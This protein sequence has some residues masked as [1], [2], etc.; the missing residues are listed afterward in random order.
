MEK[1]KK[2]RNEPGQKSKELRRQTRPM[3]VVWRRLVP[4]PG[5]V[6]RLLRDEFRHGVVHVVHQALMQVA[7][8]GQDHAGRGLGFSLQVL[9]HVGLCARTRKDGKG[10]TAAWRGEL[11][12]AERGRATKAFKL[13]L[14]GVASFFAAELYSSQALSCCLFT[15]CRSKEEKKEKRPHVRR[16]CP[17][18][19]LRLAR[20]SLGTHRNCFQEAVIFSKKA[21]HMAAVVRLSRAKWKKWSMMRQ[22]RRR[23]RR[24]AGGG[25]MARRG[26]PPVPW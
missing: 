22:R 17:D 6:V 18:E 23:G 14:T 3:G 7:V 21:E 4:Y 12:R 1:K 2:M 15:A 25:D 9:Q 19:G 16:T 13:F 24:P 10:G 20:L 11:G 8:L 26:A 5:V